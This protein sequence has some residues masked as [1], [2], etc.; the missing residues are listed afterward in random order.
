[1]IATIAFIA[2]LLLGIIITLVF[3]LPKILGKIVV[4]YSDPEGPY[5]FLELAKREYIQKL[6]RQK[7]VALRIEVRESQK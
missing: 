4:D 2:G 3:L 7:I 1:M 6:T 5:I